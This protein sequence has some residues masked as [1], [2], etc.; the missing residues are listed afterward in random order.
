MEKKF[1]LFAILVIPFL[2]LTSCGEDVGSGIRT[3]DGVTPQ[4][5]P[6]GRRPPPTLGST[7]D[8]GDGDT[9]GRVTGDLRD[10]GD[11][12]EILI[13]PVWLQS[14]EDGTF[15][16]VT[17]LPARQNIYILTRTSHWAH[18]EDDVPFVTKL[19]TITI[20]QNASFSQR[21]SANPLHWT[22]A[23]EISI[24]PFET[25][26]KLSLPETTA[27]GI[28][29]AEGTEFSARYRALENHDKVVFFHLPE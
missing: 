17:D 21:F 28:E 16:A 19:E 10:N 7:F 14:C 9:G 20:K 15:M 22:R 29:I 18:P 26:Q 6:S 3:G 12:V 8:P 13:S 1:F 24:E 27:E 4:Q 11:R 2:I 25:L 23:V 5:Q